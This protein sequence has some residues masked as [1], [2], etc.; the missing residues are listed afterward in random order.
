M[1]AIEAQPSR[2]RAFHRPVL[3]GVGALERMPPQGSTA[4][5]ETGILSVVALYALSIASFFCSSIG[6]R[7]FG[8]SVMIN[9]GCWGYA[10]PMSKEIRPA[11]R[12]AR[13]RLVRASAT[14]VTAEHKG[15]FD[16]QSREDQAHNFR[17]LRTRTPSVASL[18]SHLNSTTRPSRMVT[19]RSMRRAR[20][21]LWVAIIAAR[22]E[23]RTSCARVS[24][25]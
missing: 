7:G 12:R 19:R 15:K 21:M 14:L 4:D 9:P 6:S 16:Y 10:G 2:R 5:F 23:A 24:K 3:A 17:G 1:E 13:I 8:S 25:T 11:A 18:G 22:P 20:S